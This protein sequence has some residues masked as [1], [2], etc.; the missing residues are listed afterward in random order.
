[1][2]DVES[3]CRKGVEE[4]RRSTRD[5]A[6]EYPKTGVMGVKNVHKVDVGSM[7]TTDVERY[8]PHAEEAVKLYCTKRNLT[9][10]ET[11]A[12]RNSRMDD[13]STRM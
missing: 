13:E 6:R 7:S 1:M 10:G 5:A 2:R 3:I 9:F 11:D 4:T 8:W 12:K